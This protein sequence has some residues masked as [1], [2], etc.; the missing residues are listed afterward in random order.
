M[1]KKKILFD[2]MKNRLAENETKKVKGGRSRIAIN[3][4]SVGFIDW[5]DVIIREPNMVSNSTS[6]G[7]S[8]NPFSRRKIG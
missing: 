8:I 1:T 2:F 6:I 7:I 3:T 4:G 5:D